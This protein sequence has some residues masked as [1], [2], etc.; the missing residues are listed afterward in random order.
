VPLLQQQQQQRV[1]ELLA[2]AAQQMLARARCR[3]LA[4]T[5]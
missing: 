2:K 4:A 3:S 1:C 5:A